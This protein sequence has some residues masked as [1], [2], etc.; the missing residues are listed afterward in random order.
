MIER[1]FS[2]AVASS[3]PPAQAWQVSRQ[4]PTR[5]A[6]S[7]AEMAS[8]TPAMRSRCRAIALSPPAVFS[9]SS[10]ILMSVA[11]TALRQLSKPFAGSSSLLTCPPWTIRPLRADLGRGVHVLLEQ[12]AARDPDA[13]VGGGD[14]D[15]VRRVHVEVD[16]RRLG[17]RPQAGGASGVP[18]LGALVALRVAEEELHERGLRGPSPRRPGRSARRGLRWRSGCSELMAPSLGRSP[19]TAPPWRPG[20]T[21]CGR[22]FR[23]G[24][25]CLVTLRVALPRWESRHR[26]ALLPRN[27]VAA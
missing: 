24:R 7:A 10:G 22:R 4:K 9:I 5:S 21:A 23:R 14:V 13:V 2:T 16:A 3:I 19:G 27:A 11:S 20:R 8:Q 26:T 12:L 1:T 25:R 18:D 17:V 15:D 6:P